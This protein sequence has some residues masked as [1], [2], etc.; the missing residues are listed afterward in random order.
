MSEEAIKM[1]QKLIEEGKGDPERLNGILHSLQNGSQ[2][3][4]SDQQ[5]IE[6]LSSSTDK[7][8][9]KEELKTPENIPEPINETSNSTDETDKISIK[10]ESK[11]NKKKIVI[12]GIV[13][14]AIICGFIGTNAY[15]ASSVQIRPHQGNQ[16]AISPSVLHIQAEACNPSYFSA[17]FHNYEIT[18]IY[19]TKVL[20]VALIN[21]STIT[22]KSS[23]LLDGTFTI[24]REAVSEFANQSST[25]DPNQATVKTKLD[26]PIFG[27]IPFTV[28]KEYTGQEFANV[29]KN[30]PPGGYLC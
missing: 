23:M 6:S 28:S 11:G 17:S 13:I 9:I 15:A 8:E 26:A 14:A 19:K 18:A 22:P 29:V 10:G 2:L 3:D 16:F 25:F 7:S 30:G 1:V 20:E 12:A 21:G 5:Y 4:L 24:N 27:I